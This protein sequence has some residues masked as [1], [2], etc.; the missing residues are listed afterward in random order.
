MLFGLT[1]DILSRFPQISRREVWVMSLIS[2]QLRDAN[3]MPEVAFTALQNMQ[4][5]HLLVR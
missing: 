1:S 5:T 2:V 4:F 3:H